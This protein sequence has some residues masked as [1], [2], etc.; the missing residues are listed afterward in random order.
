MA[1]LY[2][3]TAP[4]S[5]H[6]PEEISTFLNQLIH[7]SS[8][9]SSS[10]LSFNAK[11][12]HSLSSPPPDANSDSG[13]FSQPEDRHRVARSADLSV[14]VFDSSSGGVNFSN[15]LNTCV[16]AVDSDNYDSE[17]PDASEVPTN[18][19]GRPK[20][21]SKRG[22]A[23]DVHNMSE[24]RRRSRI[25]ERMKALQN[26]IP[27]SNKTDKAS[28]LD[29][30]IEYLKQLQLQVQMLTMRNGLSLHPM[31]LPGVLQ[32]VQL[33]QTGM[34]FD[35]ENELLN[36][37]RGTDTFSANE[38]GLVQTAFNIPNQPTISNQPIAISSAANISTL[39]TSFGLEPLIQA[40][41]G[42][43]NFSSS[44]KD[45]CDEGVPQLHLDMNF[46]GKNS[47]SGMT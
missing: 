34:L 24:K 6:E 22:R 9:S 28:M 41:Y 20:P 23:A 42:P 36:T 38:E 25:N 44:S 10:C 27:N 46:T 15:S 19:T 1:D 13:L 14:S 26:L 37:N 18:N 43:F 5:G 40:H 33:P 47:S 30:A 3:T 7:N 21:P 12:I 2:G 16:G 31:W 32:S 29:E 17:G 4:T 11:Y 39:E 8:S 45:I 35:V